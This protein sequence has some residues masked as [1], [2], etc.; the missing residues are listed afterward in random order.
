[1][2]GVVPF[3]CT[4]LFDHNGLFLKVVC[5]VITEVYEKIGHAAY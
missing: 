3:I 5:R 2:G 4:R 1:M